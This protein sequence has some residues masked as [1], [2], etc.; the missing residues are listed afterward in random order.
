MK[1]TLNYNLYGNLTKSADSVE[2]GSTEKGNRF[3][4]GAVSM[5]NE[6][7]H[8]NADG[9]WETTNTYRV[10]LKIYENRVGKEKFEAFK[11]LTTK[12]KLKVVAEAQDYTR[13]DG[14]V[15]RSYIVKDYEV[16]IPHQN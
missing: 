7:N 14:S 5:V 3:V 16:L 8:K 11:A 2:I 9:K 1:T 4:K 10:N 6:E 15:I 13:K 12:D